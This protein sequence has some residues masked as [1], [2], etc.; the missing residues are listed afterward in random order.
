MVLDQF[1][2]KMFYAFLEETKKSG[3]PTRVGLQQ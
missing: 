2:K 1:S 3:L